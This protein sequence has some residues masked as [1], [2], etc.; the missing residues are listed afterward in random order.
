M[1]FQNVPAPTAPGMRSEPS[2][3]DVAALSVR[4]S[5]ESLSTGF[6]SRLGSA[7]LFAVTQ[8]PEPQV[9]ARSL[10]HSVEER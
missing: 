9:L 7:F 4:I 10:A 1:P 6:F 5:A 8:P 2:K 3:R